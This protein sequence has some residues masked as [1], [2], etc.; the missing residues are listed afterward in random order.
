MLRKNS[1]DNHFEDFDESFKLVKK[2]TKAGFIGAGLGLVAG[3]A[4][5]IYVG[6]SI[7]GYAE[8]L[9]QAPHAV[10]YGVDGICAV[11]GG[12]FIAGIGAF[13]AQIPGIYR[14]SQRM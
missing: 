11:V 6:E 13:V 2:T 10:Q 1:I 4:G 7:N 9:K 8:I 3:I 12:S 5:G 14:L